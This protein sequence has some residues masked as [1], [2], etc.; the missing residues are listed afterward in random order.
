MK[1]FSWGLLG[2][3]ANVVLGAGT[4]AHITDLHFDMHYKLGVDT[5]GYCRGSTP[6][7]SGRYGTRSNRCDSPESLIRETLVWITTRKPRVDFVLVSGDLARRAKVEVN[8]N[9][10]WQELDTASELL[11]NIVGNPVR[12]IPSIGGSDLTPESTC[13]QSDP[14]FER[15]L[16]GTW[17]PFLREFLDAGNR[18]SFL[19]WGCYNV[20][21]REF[22]LGIIVLNTEFWAKENDYSEQLDCEPERVG[23]KI[24]TWADNLLQDYARQG[25]KV[26]ITGNRKFYTDDAS[27]GYRP[28]TLRGCDQL[29][30][31]LAT[32]HRDTIA[33]HIFGGSHED[34]FRLIANNVDVT[35]PNVSGVVLV[36][37]AVVPVYNPAIRVYEYSTSTGIITDYVQYFADLEAANAPNADLRFVEEYRATTAYG[38]PSFDLSSWIAFSARLETDAVLRG[39]VEKHRI[40]SSGKPPSPTPAPDDSIIGVVFAVVCA[41][42]VVLA[43]LVAR[44]KCR[45]FKNKT[46][47]QELA[48][49]LR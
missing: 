30:V 14:Q 36:S 3:C 42:I 4:F 26:I 9:E 40:V 31:K 2:L 23:G 17:E 21:L 13:N 8:P 44:W 15:L 37:P 11:H 19:Q 28:A 1:L 20:T 47:E 39:V 18:A 35:K 45:Q 33:A 41:V 48:E 22:G 46:Y 34:S 12:I 38:L 25:L 16:N 6:G 43:G 32:D 10:T 7:E 27:D 24:F 29:Y 49:G 5:L